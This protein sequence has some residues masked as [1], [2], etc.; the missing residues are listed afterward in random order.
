VTGMLSEL[1]LQTLTERRKN[2]RLSLFYRALSEESPIQVPDTIKVKQNQ[3]RTDN[4]R[5]CHPLP[6]SRTNSR[7]HS[8]YPKTVRDWNGLPREAMC[9][10]TLSS[11]KDFLLGKGVDN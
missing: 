8:F 4:G 1:E 9:K 7:H 3:G 2:S 5:A 10:L 11:F 6:V